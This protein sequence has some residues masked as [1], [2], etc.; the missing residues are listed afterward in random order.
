MDLGCC[1]EAVGP[2]VVEGFRDAAVARVDSLAGRVDL[3]VKN[4]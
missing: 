3:R 1:V 2:V 4:E